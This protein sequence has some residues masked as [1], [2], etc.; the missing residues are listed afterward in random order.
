MELIFKT[1]NPRAVICDARMSETVKSLGYEGG[2]YEY[3]EASAHE[4]N[5]AFVSFPAF[6]VSFAM[7]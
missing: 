4:V 5:D 7:E 6:E 2:L 3:A 1:L